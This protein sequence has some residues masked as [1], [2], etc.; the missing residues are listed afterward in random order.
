MS[1]NT[2]PPT[3]KALLQETKNGPLIPKSIP[4]PTPG[5][6]SVVVKILANLLQHQTP[7]ILSG[8]AGFT[9][10]TPMIPGGRAVGRI[11]ATGPDTTCLSEG[12]LVLLEPFIRARDDADTWIFWGAMEGTSEESKKLFADNWRYATFAEYVKAPL[13]N[14]CALDEKRLCGELGYT[15]PELVQLSVDVVAYSGLKGIGL[16][17]GERLV[18]TPATGLF[19]GAA[20]GVAVAMGATVLVTGRNERAL[21]RLVDAHPKLV[22]S[23]LRTNDV[24]VDVKNLQKHGTVD[25]FLEF[26][27]MGAEGST[28]VRAAFGALKQ[29]GRACIMGFG[30]G[31][32]K[33]VEIPMMDIVFK[34]ITV[35]GHAMYRGQDV[36][37][38]IKMAEAG[39]LKLGKER[40]F[41]S[42]TGFK[43]DD[44]ERGFDWVGEN[45]ELGQ[46]AVLVP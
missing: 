24:E 44:F 21:R 22:S 2:L 32:M 20:V 31:A 6:G 45:H 46:M 11:A 34:S 7:G 38:M 43:M 29:Y 17:P 26:T 18:V 13:E 16:R 25:A 9:Y 10:P 41:D 5:P 35:H 14:T 30:G 40:G 37:E 12:Q 19:S 1:T 23:V 3:M 15:I 42:V 4:T 39:V 33:D 27:P 36:K 28:H 8:K